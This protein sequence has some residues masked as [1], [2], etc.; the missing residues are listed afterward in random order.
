[1]Y[2]VITDPEL[3]CGNQIV[4]TD[5]GEYVLESGGTCG[6]DRCGVCGMRGISHVIFEPCS[7]PPHW[8]DPI[9]DPKEAL[10]DFVAHGRALEED[11]CAQRHYHE[12]QASEVDTDA[13]KRDR[14]QQ[15][16]EADE[17]QARA[18]AEWDARV[19]AMRAAIV[20]Q[21]GADTFP[22]D[23]GDGRVL[24]VPRAPFERWALG[25][26]KEL[27]HLQ[28]AWKP[29]SHSGMKLNGDDTDHTDWIIG[30]GLEPG[31]AYK[32]PISAVSTRL[33][34]ELQKRLGKFSAGVIVDAGPVT[35]T[36]GSDVLVLP[37]LD[38]A[39]LPEMA[40][41]R[42]VIT[43]RGGKGAH[44]AQVAL[45]RGLTIMLVDDACTRYPAGLHVALEPSKGRIEILGRKE[46][47][48]ALS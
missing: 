37:N 41:A 11:G 10:R 25:R 18:E 33:M 9:T 32:E 14:E 45:E 29:V 7:E 28:P 16:R 8:W 35:G 19:V 12:P 40:K 26:A 48:L 31:D 20:E 42:A 46:E 24:T 21:A 4:R 43:E 6:N 3:R 2:E 15:R 22:M 38:P 44:L 27:R 47:P 39:H 30:A 34:S 36:V 13:M 23:L 17:A 5:K 1:V